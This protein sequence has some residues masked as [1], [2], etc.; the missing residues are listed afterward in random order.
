MA[1]ATAAAA[2]DHGA[3]L[4]GHTV[5][6][7]AP[8]HHVEPTAFGIS[9]GGFVALA[10]LVVFAIML[11]ARVPAIIAGALDARIGG[12]REQLDTA[13]KLRKEAEALKAEYEAK[14]RDADAEI[15]TLKAGAERQAAEIVAKARDDATKLIERHKAMSEAKIAGAER[16]AIDEIRRRAAEAAGAAAQALIV[17]RVDDATDKRLVDDAIAGI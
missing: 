7:D 4:E 5:A 10:M 9:P 6:H 14:A 1:E 13:A 17:E 2:P 12:I 16:S 8:E 3:V 11:K 15:A